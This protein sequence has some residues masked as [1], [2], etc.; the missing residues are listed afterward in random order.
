MRLAIRLKSPRTVLGSPVPE[1]IRDRGLGVSRY[2]WE[3]IRVTGEHARVDVWFRRG[4]GGARERSALVRAP[5]GRR[6]S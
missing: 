4:V 1:L 2:G 3:S 5:V 6:G